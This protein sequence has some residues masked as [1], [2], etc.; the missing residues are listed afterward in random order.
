[1]EVDEAVLALV[2]A[3]L[4]AG[5]HAP[6]HVAPA[7]VDQ[8]TQQR[9]LRRGPGDLS[10]VGDAGTPATRAGRVVLAG[11]HVVYPSADRSAEGVD[12]VTVGELHHRPLR[13]L[14]LAPTGPGALALALPVERVHGQDA[15]TEDLLNGD[16]DL[17]LVRVR[18]DQEGV[19]VP[20]EL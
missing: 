12:A 17:G 16:L 3:A 19:P 13:V 2:A 15:D 11:S 7:L 14:A 4:V 9:L 1:T 20:V 10:E 8:R 18:V 6:V 5:R